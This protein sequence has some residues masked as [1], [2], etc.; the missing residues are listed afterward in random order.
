MSGSQRSSEEELGINLGPDPAPAAIGCTL[1]SADLRDR[2]DRWRSVIDVALRAKRPT[3]GGVLLEFEP[4]PEITRELAHLVAAEGECC[5][6]AT[7]SLVT[8]PSATLVEVT[9]DGAGAEAARELFG[10]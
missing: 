9:A 8:T 2:E 7:W 10:A 1:P 4:R 3:D 6:W 5:A